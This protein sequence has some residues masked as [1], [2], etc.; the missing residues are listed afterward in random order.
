[1][2]LVTRH[3]RFTSLELGALIS[4]LQN[5]DVELIVEFVY[6][7]QKCRLMYFTGEI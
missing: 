7:M 1:M 6:V 2:G 3:A 5:F 4:K